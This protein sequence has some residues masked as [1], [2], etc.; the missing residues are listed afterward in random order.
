MLL[1]FQELR[2]LRD[3]A[4]ECKPIPFPQHAHMKISLQEKQSTTILML[5][6]MQFGQEHHS[7][8]CQV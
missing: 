1:C 6:R 5:L 2:A 3:E 7:S 4:V 8:Q